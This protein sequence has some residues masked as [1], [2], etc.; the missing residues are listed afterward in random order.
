MRRGFRRPPGL[1]R[2]GGATLGLRAHGGYICEACG[3]QVDR[4]GFIIPGKL[5]CTLPRPAFFASQA[6]ARRW[7]LLLLREKGGVIRQLRRQ[8]AYDLHVRLGKAPW[9]ETVPPIKL[10]KYIADF[11]YFN[12]TDQ[13]V[14]EDVKGAG[15]T[16]IAIWK[17][18]HVEA[19]YGIKVNIVK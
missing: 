7:R 10:G 6:E 4:G 3:A 8:V 18:K 17:M 14:V 9:G 15:L 1:R 12:D 2:I 16:D 19:E 11:T 13:L 5:C